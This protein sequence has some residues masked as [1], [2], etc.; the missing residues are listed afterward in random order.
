MWW[1]L[2]VGL[3]VGRIDATAWRAIAAHPTMLR[4]VSVTA[5][6]ASAQ[7]TLFSY[8]VIA[9]RDTIVATPWMITLLLSTFGIAGFAGNVVA[10]RVADRRGPP[11]VIH[12]TLGLLVAAFVLW[13]VLFDLGPGTVAIATAFVIAALWGGGNFAANS[14]QQVRLVDLA[15]PLAAVSIAL[16]TSAIYLGQFVGA[17]SGGYVL[18]HPF[19]DP[20]TKALPWVALPVFFIAIAVS[21]T[22]QRRIERVGPVTPSPRAV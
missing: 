7:F 10:G 3:F 21:V 5:L 4:V 9:Y 15:P 6:Q 13:I 19:T 18:A 1:R 8:V 11:L 12:C 14:M 16:N 17:A 2:P 22:A 20:A